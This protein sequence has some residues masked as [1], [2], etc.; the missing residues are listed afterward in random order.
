MRF[1][2][3]YNKLIQKKQALKQLFPRFLVRPLLDLRKNSAMT[4]MMFKV[5]VRLSEQLQTATMDRLADEKRRKADRCVSCGNQIATLIE[6]N[7]EAGSCE[8]LFI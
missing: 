6:Q 4:A 1:F 7:P 3:H 2:F 5:C 8:K